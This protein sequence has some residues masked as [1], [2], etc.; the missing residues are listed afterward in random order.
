MAP[1]IAPGDPDAA[2]AIDWERAS[3][4]PAPPESEG[5]SPAGSKHCECVSYLGLAPE[6]LFQRGMERGD[7]VSRCVG[8][9]SHVPCPD[10]HTAYSECAAATKADGLTAA[11]RVFFSCA[12]RFCDGTY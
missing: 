10:E 6:G 8:L 7:I 4:C 12:A 3:A 5:C 1:A 2:E 9:M 11:E